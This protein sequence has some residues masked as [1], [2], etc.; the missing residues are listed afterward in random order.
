[1]YWFNSWF[2]RFQVHLQVSDKEVL[3]FIH[4]DL[5]LTIQSQVLVLPTVPQISDGLPFLSDHHQI[6][7][8]NL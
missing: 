3:I 8:H 2:T 1:M 6:S 5:Q 4:D 7:P